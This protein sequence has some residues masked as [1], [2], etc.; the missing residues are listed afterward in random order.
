[1]VPTWCTSISSQFLI[2]WEQFEI[3]V[4]LSL[5]LA[6]GYMLLRICDVVLFGQMTTA[7]KRHPK[8]VVLLE[9]EG[10]P[11]TYDFVH[12]R[13]NIAKEIASTE[14]EE[15]EENL[16]CKADTDFHFNMPQHVREEEEDNLET[17]IGST[18]YP[19]KVSIRVEEEVTSYASSSLQGEN[20]AMGLRKRNPSQLNS[21]AYREISAVEGEEGYVMVNKK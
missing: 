5:S 2:S 13:P 19:S 8:D 17:I 10:D 15:E 21:T 18:S 7:S 11:S 3:L 1:M 16:L 14:E 4:L 9:D 12:I 6:F 20:N